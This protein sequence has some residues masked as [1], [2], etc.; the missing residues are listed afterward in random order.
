MLSESETKK[1]L[2]ALDWPRLQAEL[3]RCGPTQDALDDALGHLLRENE[4]IFPHPDPKKEKER[5]TFLAQFRSYAVGALG[6]EPAGAVTEVAELQE[7]VEGRYRQV[8]DTL[9]ECDISKLAPDVRTSAYIT[10]AAQQYD[11]MVREM[12]D[13]LRT[14]NDIGTFF[15]G[16]LAMKE[17][18]P[19][20]P[21]GVLEGIVVSLTSA[22]LMEGYKNNWFDANGVVNLPAL[23]T[24]SEE[25]CFKAGSTEVLAFVWR[26]WRKTEQRLRYIGAHVEDFT[27]E[28]MPTWAPEGAEFI[29]VFQPTTEEL[30]DYVANERLAG[31]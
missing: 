26:A 15:Q 5:A 14:G 17:D 27:S 11:H 21:D 23:P 2:K 19:F 7:M 30:Y 6:E 10:R 16:P 20:S 28:N 3:T 22:L 9:A 12:T 29:S 31:R 1:A 13:L 8:L 18:R 25:E 4:L 24:V